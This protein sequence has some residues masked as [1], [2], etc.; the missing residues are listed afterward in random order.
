M[1]HQALREAPLQGAPRHA[2]HHLEH[3]QPRQVRPREGHL[4]EGRRPGKQRHVVPVVCK[5]ATTLTPATILKSFNNVGVYF[6]KPLD[7]HYSYG[8]N[9]RW[10]GSSSP[11]F[12]DLCFASL[13]SLLDMPF[14]YMSAYD[15]RHNRTIV[16]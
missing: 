3:R 8:R 2:D 15:S 1:L 12:R 13:D 11:T 7:K 10:Q 16:L 6:D 5:V 14:H 9:K 4:L